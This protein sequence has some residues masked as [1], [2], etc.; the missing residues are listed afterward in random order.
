VIRRIPQP[1]TQPVPLAA[2]VL[3]LIACLAW[4]P[5][6]SRAADFKP[7][8]SA[9]LQTFKLFDLGVADADDDGNLDLFTTNHKFDSR[10]LLGDGHGGLSESLVPLGLSPTQAFPGFE[11]LHLLPDTT[12]PGLYLYATDRNEPRD[13]FHIATTAMPASGHLVFGAQ[14]LQ[15]EDSVNATVTTSR[16]PDGSSVLD[17]DAAPGALIDVSVEHIDLPIGVH[18]DA[19]TDPAQIKVGAAAVPATTPDFALSLRDRHGF[20]FADF[21]GDRRSDLFV[22]TG[23]L[24]GEITDPFFTGRQSD[25]LLLGSGHGFRTATVTSGLVKGVC[26]GRAAIPVD[27][28]GDGKLDLVESCDAGP[29]QIYA[30]DGAGHFH[31]VA[32]PPTIGD[33]YRAIDLVG[34]RRPELVI[35]AADTVEVWRSVDGTWVLAQQLPTLNGDAPIQ[36]L[37]E[38]DVDVDGDLDLFAASRGGNTMLMNVGGKLRRRSLKKLNL[39]ERGTFAAAFADYDNDG[40]PDLDLLPQGLFEARKGHFRRTGQLAYGPLPNGR[41]GYGTI[42]WP[43]L[44]EDGRRDPISDRGRGEFAAEQIV[45]RRRNRVEGGNWLEVDLSG[46]RGNPQAIGASI[47]VQTALG[48]SWGW[49]G[50]S[51]DSR[52]SSGHYRVYFGLGSAK[53]IERLVVTWPNGEKQR[54]ETRRINRILRVPY[55]PR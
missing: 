34:D 35:A 31:Q 5:A 47:R 33:T 50:Q 3:A 25:E 40:D 8:D 17:F 43:D 2:C 13:P 52:Y 26:R 41:I 23:G 36:H 53:E 28:D 9:E 51:E 11:D 12:A 16:L 20:G 1:P 22:A 32:A 45:D 42:S 21:N 4:H 15:V 14:D 6:N 24:G 48:S 54:I 29:A 30:G 46:P 49:V 37:A 38:A 55:S 19:P 39:P 44:D 18:V 7:L 27:F 10:F